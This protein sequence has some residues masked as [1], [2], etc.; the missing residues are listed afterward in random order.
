MFVSD[1]RRRT[2]MEVNM[3]LLYISFG[4]ESY[5]NKVD[6]QLI[7]FKKLGL[8]CYLIALQN[9]KMN[10]YHLNND[11][12]ELLEF[13]TLPE[14]TLLKF[15]SY[16]SA[17]NEFVLKVYKTY[18]FEYCYIR[19]LVINLLFLS[20]AIRKMGKHLKVLYE[21]PTVPLDHYD[22]HFKNIAQ[23]LEV[24]YYKMFVKKS[25]YKEIVILQND[26]ALNDLIYPISN[27]INI[28]KFYL[29]DRKPI[30]EGKIRFVAIAHVM[31]W[32]GYDRFIKSMK[33][34]KG[35]TD[36]ELT[37]ISQNTGENIKLKKLVNELELNDKIK[38]KK[39]CTFNELDNLVDNYHIAL[40]SFGYHRRGAKYDTSIKNKEYCAWGIPFVYSCDDKSFTNEFK[41][42]YKVP[43]DESLI[44]IEQI[45][46]WYID[47][48]DDDYRKEMYNYAIKHLNFENEYRALFVE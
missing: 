34:Y 48:Y 2:E 19:R 24:V 33:E 16:K 23:N 37:I 29:H 15:F 31:N 36:I 9:K 41:Y 43:A 1:R 12:M 22:S 10:L 11:D 27:C 18:K 21:W 20:K 42:N 7:A 40:G 14:L 47:L 46:E 35:L 45:I 32:H 6:A 38:F 4:Y 26:I 8:D 25:V 13:R 17:I 3:K 30:M 44:N 5:K 28:D 39:E